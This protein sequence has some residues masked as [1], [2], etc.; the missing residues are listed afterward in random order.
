MQA[1][2]YGVYNTRLTTSLNDSFTF[3]L[4]TRIMTSKLNKHRTVLNS[5]N[6]NKNDNKI[7]TASLNRNFRGAGGRS[8]HCSVKD[9]KE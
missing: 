9:Q 3:V 5:N 4:V 8:Y 2:Y 1:V 7:Y 6:N